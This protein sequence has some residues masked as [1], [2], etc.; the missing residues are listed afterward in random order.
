MEH[1][2]VRVT[3]TVDQAGDIHTKRLSDPRDW[4]HALTLNNLVFQPSFWGSQSRQ[5]Y[6]TTVFARPPFTKTGGVPH[7]FILPSKAKKKKSPASSDE[8]S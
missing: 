5:A 4:L 3:K 6:H 1:L 8:E 7:P 2:K